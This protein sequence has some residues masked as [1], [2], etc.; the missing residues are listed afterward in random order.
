MRSA[1][2]HD[3]DV[4]PEPSRDPAA[5]AARLGAIAARCEALLDRLEAVPGVDM[6][7]VDRLA[8][9]TAVLGIRTAERTAADR[10]A[11]PDQAALEM[12]FAAGVAAG[13]A[14]AA[15]R[16]RVPAQHRKDRRPF[17]GQLTLVKVRGAV[18]PGLAA[19]WALLRHPG[20]HAWTLKAMTAKHVALA[21]T[22]AVAIPSAAIAVHVALAPQV[23]ASG[24][25]RAS[26]PAPAAS[27]ENAARIPAYSP[28]AALTKPK[29]KAGTADAKGAGQL[30]P[31]IQA[32]YVSP[33][34]GTSP[35][36]QASP[37]SQP[38]AP[39]VTVAGSL[40]VS[41]QSVNL[42]TAI[43]GTAT[44]RIRA[45][46]GDASWSIQSIPPDLVLTLPDGTQV[47][48]GQSYDLSKGQS[49]DLTVA[50]ALNLDGSDLVTFA[51]GSATVS[52]TVPLPVP[53]TVPSA[54]PSVL[55]SI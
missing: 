2:R 50:L 12:A 41:P 46:G 16:A 53:V 55:P 19:A 30:T 28:V 44:V 26:T 7:V 45:W 8:S 17:P 18:L 5:E 22:A 47:N 32:P 31:V 51:V 36:S 33:Q 38:E 21:V 4:P 1:A 6:A 29:T 11:A 43:T 42:V 3:K 35:S 39:A 54:V 9:E 52:V 27:I 34:S 14:R 25:Y 37:S 49:V 40:V 15:A 20:G 48:P 13:E 23:Q 24:A 10:D